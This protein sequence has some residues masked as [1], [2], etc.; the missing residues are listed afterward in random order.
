[1]LNFNTILKKNYIYITFLFIFSILFNQ[2]YG[3]Q[4]VCPIDSFASFNAGYDVLNGKFPFKDY[5]TITGPFIALTQAFLFKLLGV[6]WF[7]Y[8]FHASLV[9]FIFT[10]STFYTLY[11]FKLETRYCFFYSLFVSI[12]SYPSTGTPYVDHQS[13]I[14]SI[15]SIYFFILALKTG[16]S[17][18]WFFLPIILVLSFLTKQAPTGHILIIIS[19]LSVFYFIFNFNIKNI[20]MGV[21]GSMLIIFIFLYTLHMSGISFDSFYVQYILFPLSLGEDRL[22]FIFPLEFNRII[23][24]YKLVHL[25]SVLLIIYCVKQVAKNYRFIFNNDLL[26]I[27]SLIFSSWAFIIHQLMTVNG[28]FIYFLIPILCA[29]SHIYYSQNFDRKKYVLPTLVIFTLISS[30]Y[31]GYKYVHQRDFWDLRSADMSEAVD[32]SILSKKLKGLKWKSCLRPKDTDKEISELLEVV[33]IIKNEQKEKSI[34]TDYQ[35]ISVILSEYDNS[36]SK[37]WFHYH[38][39]PE[40]GSK[41]FKKYKKFFIEKFKENKVKV[42][43]VIKPMMGGDKIIENVLDSSCYSKKVFNKML[44]IYKILNCNDIKNY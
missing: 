8:V 43:Y 7:S 9:N 4:G 16:K 36:P 35:F 33:E 41:H 14:L 15:I 5:W 30:L 20:L 11:K 42:V 19:F 6:S 34:I 27:F 1:M 44:N 2:Y 40:R 28:I 12:L 31:Y 25:S 24:R 17:F 21:A 37:V 22:G 29:F 32:A 39:N 13:A 3:N 38:V 18:Y 23:L 26:I 10:I